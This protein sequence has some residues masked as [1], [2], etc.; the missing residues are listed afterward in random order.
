[1]I[2]AG[3]LRTIDQIKNRS[4]SLK[5]AMNIPRL[6]VKTAEVVP[7][8]TDLRRNYWDGEHDSL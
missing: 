3:I 8:D 7:T 4:G 6:K 2:E 1:M 5:A